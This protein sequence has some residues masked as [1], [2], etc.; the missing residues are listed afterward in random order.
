VEIRGRI[1]S[2]TSP[3]Q[4]HLPRAWASGILADALVFFKKK[5]GLAASLRCA[6]ASG[7]L[8]LE[9]LVA[10]APVFRPSLVPVSILPR[11]C[12]FPSAPHLR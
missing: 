5:A 12:L 10:R 3:W 2:A 6:A 8:R 11:L 9:A 7:V 1:D 4:D